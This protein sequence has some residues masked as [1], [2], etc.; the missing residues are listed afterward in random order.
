MLRELRHAL[1]DSVLSRGDLPTQYTRTLQDTLVRYIG[2]LDDVREGIVSA[3][4]N[5]L[6]WL[7]EGVRVVI[8]LPFS[9]L[10]WL[11]MMSQRRADLITAGGIFKLASGLVGT[12]GF[13]SGVM[14]IV[15][16]WDQFLSFLKT[17]HGRFF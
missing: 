1:N 12:I 6:V 17:W 8:A 13:L 2:T 7:G 16:G 10:A 14:G 4:K 5:P 11:G 15:L 9:V 3:L